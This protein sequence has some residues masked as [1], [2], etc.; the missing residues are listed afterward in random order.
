VTTGAGGE[1]FLLA[2]AKGTE[3]SRAAPMAWVG[4]S[5]LLL[6]T[7]FGFAFTYTVFR[8]G[9][10]WA[11]AIVGYGTLLA[12][13]GTWHQLGGLTLQPDLSG[14]RAEFL[15]GR[16]ACFGWGTFEGF[17]AYKMARRRLALGLADPVVVNRLFLFGCWF[18]LMGLMP[19][20]FFVSR[21]A[22]RA[23]ELEW[24]LQIPP[25]LVASG[26]AVALVLTFFPP[27]RYLNWV[28]RTAQPHSP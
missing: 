25:K 22:F 11:L 24:A 15:T 21:W 14:P 4:F 3:A 20:T 2:F 28:R 13:W 7:G 17:R 12:L 27:R 23:S 26:M 9:E 18:G 10:R 19:I 6:A 1:F 16:V 8:R 5:L